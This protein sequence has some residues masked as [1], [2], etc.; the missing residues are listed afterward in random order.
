MYRDFDG[1][2]DMDFLTGEFVDA[3]WY[4]ENVAGKGRCPRFA[5]GRRVCSPDGSHLAVDLCMFDPV[6]ADFDG[7]GKEDLV[8]AEEGGRVAV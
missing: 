2:G 3:F 8:A 6:L 1:D 5:K 4:F 7:D